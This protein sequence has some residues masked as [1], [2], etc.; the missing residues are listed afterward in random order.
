MSRSLAHV[1]NQQ[2]S[3]LQQLTQRLDRSSPSLIFAER[4]A[5]LTELEV[6]LS[7]AVRRHLRDAQSDCRLISVQLHGS[8]VRV[9]DRQ[10]IDLASV[11]SHMRELP[12]VQL[13]ERRAGLD[14]A[15]RRVETSTRAVLAGAFAELDVQKSALLRLNPAAVLNRGF[16]LLTGPDGNV[17]GSVTAVQPGDSIRAVVRD[18]TIWGM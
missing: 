12:R 16:A 3:D 13:A 1:L 14:Q 4:R 18:G 2:R 11:Q 9:L 6:R 8:G 7:S 17:V 15:Q 5:R 10:R